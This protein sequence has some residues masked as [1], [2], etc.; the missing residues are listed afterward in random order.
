[1]DK[2]EAV[3]GNGTNDA[4]A[5]SKSDVGFS[6]PKKQVI[7]LFLIIIFLFWLL[8]FFIE[9]GKMLKH[10]IIQSLVELILLI[11]LYLY[12]PKFIKEDDIVRSVENDI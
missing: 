5:L 11:I 4:R 2:I 12:A 7:L 1:M 10:I 3:T 9:N 6:M 8:Q